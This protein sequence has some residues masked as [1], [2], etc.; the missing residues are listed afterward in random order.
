MVLFSGFL[1]EVWSLSVETICGRVAS[2][3]FVFPSDWRRF[4]VVPL[5]SL[6]QLCN[7]VAK[8]RHKAP[9]PKGQ[10][11]VLVALSST[12]TRTQ[13]AEGKDESMDLRPGRFSL[14]LVRRKFLV[15]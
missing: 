7:S 2:R 3:R 5:A 4:V 6:R 12:R 13:A 8:N 1:P 14:T 9:E 10:D 11:C 15:A